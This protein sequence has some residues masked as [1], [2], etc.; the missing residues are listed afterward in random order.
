MYVFSRVRLITLMTIVLMVMAVLLTSAKYSNALTRRPPILPPMA[1]TNVPISEAITLKGTEKIPKK[2]IEYSH[3]II[4]TPFSFELPENASTTFDDNGGTWDII[5]DHGKEAIMVD[6]SAQG[7]KSFSES[8]NDW[9]TL[10][11]AKEVE[12]SFSSIEETNIAS[13]FTALIG[14]PFHY[15]LFEVVENEIEK[16]YLLII[17]TGPIYSGRGHL[18]VRTATP[19]GIARLNSVAKT[20]QTTEATP[21]AND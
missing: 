16:Y 8:L 14:I 12:Y 4:K 13:A 15:E 11:G 20:L 21:H 19:N 2:E 7:D 1:R 6:Y 18:A 9:V 3:T 10:W 5:M 17:D